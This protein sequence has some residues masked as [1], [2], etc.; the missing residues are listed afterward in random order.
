MGQ[1]KINLTNPVKILQSPVVFIVFQ[2]M[3][4]QD[5]FAFWFY[6]LGLLWLKFWFVELSFIVMIFKKAFTPLCLS[7]VW[8]WPRFVNWDLEDFHKNVKMFRTRPNFANLILQTL[9]IQNYFLDNSKCHGYLNGIVVWNL[10]F[11]KFKSLNLQNQ[12]LILFCFVKNRS[13]K[14]WFKTLFLKNPAN[15]TTISNCLLFFL[16]LPSNLVEH[17]EARG[18][19]F[20]LFIIEDCVFV[21]Q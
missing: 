17:Q 4:S 13:S 6:S 11:K 7:Y 15:R 16:F 8:V 14:I 5:I 10:K 19:S 20:W 3:I 12:A 18:W 9:S 2:T 1:Y 21:L